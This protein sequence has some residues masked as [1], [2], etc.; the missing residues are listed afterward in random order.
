VQQVVVRLYKSLYLSVSDNADG[1]LY[2]GFS[3][4]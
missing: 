1:R 4:L 2:N 3:M